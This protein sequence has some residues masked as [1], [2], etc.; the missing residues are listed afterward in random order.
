MPGT[1]YILCAI[2]SFVCSALL[3]RGYR[4]S[5]V[6]MLFWSAICFLGLA[7]DNGLIYFDEIVWPNVDLS[8]W[9]KLPG[10]FALVALLYGLVWDS[11]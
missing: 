11:K 6:N 2:T 9:R 1:V 5:G 3:W 8:I 7:V 4:R 10:L